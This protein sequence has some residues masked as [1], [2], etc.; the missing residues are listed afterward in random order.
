MYSP[1][2]PT[3]GQGRSNL[4]AGRALVGCGSAGGA[5]EP[6][7][8]G[9]AASGRGSGGKGCPRP[10]QPSQVRV[11]LQF[12]SLDMK[13]AGR[14]RRPSKQCEMR[15][16]GSGNG[17]APRG[18]GHLSALGSG[19]E[20]GTVCARLQLRVEAPSGSSTALVA[21]ACTESPGEG[22]A[23]SRS[24]PLGPCEL[25]PAI[26]LARAAVAAGRWLGVRSPGRPFARPARPLARQTA[27]AAEHRR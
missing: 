15:G 6:A 9:T 19:H 3:G 4:D 26:A 7:L 8:A 14:A 18:S 23:R 16:P 2:V 5:G 12:R 11:L 13:A 24:T 1:A 27:L 20:L 17:A 21:A 22:S 10:R 25:F